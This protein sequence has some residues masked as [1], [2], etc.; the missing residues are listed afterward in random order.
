MAKTLKSRSRNFTEF[1]KHLMFEIVR[2]KY[3]HIVDN[4]KTDA[5]NIEQK[6]VAWEHIA[7]EYNCQAQTGPRTSKQL[8]ALYDILKKNARS[9]LN[10][11][12]KN[13]YKTGG[14]TYVPRSS[15]LDEKIVCTLGAQFQPLTN[16]F[17]SSADYPSETFFTTGTGAKSTSTPQKSVQE[18]SNCSFLANAIN[19]NVI[20]CTEDAVNLEVPSSTLQQSTSSHGQKRKLSKIPE[21]KKTQLEILTNRVVKRKNLKDQYD[22]Q[23]QKQKMKILKIEEEIKKSQLEV[24]K[25]EIQNNKVLHE[26]EIAIKQKELEA[27]CNEME[28]K[29]QLYELDIKNMQSLNM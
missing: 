6:N 12:K 15:I 18:E 11:D 4:K 14:G 2:N 5:V 22:E 9:N 17:D 24:I 8:R 3:L 1:E 25:Q 20:L 10:E 29:K 23:I 19:E 13:F 27:K 21:K 28:Y 7:N 26:M 16:N